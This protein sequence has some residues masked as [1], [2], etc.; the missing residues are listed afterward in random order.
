MRTPAGT[1]CKFYHEDFYRG[2]NLQECRLVKANSESMRW[3]PV[4]CAHCPVPDILAA[5]ASPNLEL[6]LTI[7]PRLLGLGRTMVVE[8]YCFRHHIPIEDP[9]IGCPK[10]IEDRPGLDLFRQALEKDDDE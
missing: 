10:C 1:E 9:Y 6:K 7:Q 4:D 2:R 5:N 8:A 3:K